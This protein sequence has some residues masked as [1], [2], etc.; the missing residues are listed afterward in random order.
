MVLLLRYLFDNVQ[1][2]NRVE[3]A[4]LGNGL[5]WA[6]V[7]VPL[8]V[9]TWQSVQRLLAGPAGAAEPGE[10]SSTL[11]LSVLYLLALAGVVVTL[12]SLGVALAYALRW[13]LGETQTLGNFLFFH[14]L[15]LSMGITFAVLWAYYGRIL[16]GEINLELDPLR[17]AGLRRL[18]G[19]ILALAGNGVVFFGVWWLLSVLVDLL[20]GNLAGADLLRTRGQHRPGGAAGG[21]PGLVE[22]LAAPAGRSSP[23]DRPG[24]SRPPLACPQKLSLPG[25]FPDR[26]RRHGQ[27]RGAL[28]PGVER[29][30]GQ[31]V[32]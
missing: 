12:S 7:G 3:V 11:R 32:R 21:T 26:G 8:W 16:H 23:A 9:Y 5:A 1:A 31:S 29:G 24:R 17:Q 2:L 13:G 25:A 18:Y 28:L 19:Y 22:L 27:R 14:S 15:A 4:W 10:R 20:F 30:V 6:L